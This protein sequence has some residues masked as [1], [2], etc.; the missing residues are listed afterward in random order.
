MK[1][2]DAEEAGAAPPAKLNC[3]F[4]R[5]ALDASTSYAL[6]QS[7]SRNASAL[8]RPHPLSLAQALPVVLEPEQQ[9]DVPFTTAG[10]GVLV[11]TS[12]ADDDLTCAVDGT[13]FLAT[14]AVAAGPHVIRLR[15]AG[16]KALEASLKHLPASQAPDAKP[17]HH[18]PKVTF[19]KLPVL[20]VGTPIYLDFEREAEHTALLQVDS[21]Q[22]M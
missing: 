5:V 11:V 16:R 22:I 1:H 8:I 19:A 12:S 21:R 7:G 9:L 17:V 2:A 20:A 4:P 6:H 15:N 18:A 10:D 3:Q 13:S 14:R